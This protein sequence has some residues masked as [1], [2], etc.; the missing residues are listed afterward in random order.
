MKKYSPFIWMI[1]FAS[2]LSFAQD[3]HQYCR[4]MEHLHQ[5]EAQAHQHLLYTQANALTSDYD[6]KYHRLAWTIDPAKRFVAG[7]ITSY[8][9]P[10]V[11][12][13]TTIHFDFSDSLSVKEA[14][15]NGLPLNTQ[16]ANNLL[17]IELPYSLNTGQLDSVTIAYEGVPSSTGFGAFEQNQHNGQP[18]IWTLSEPYGAREWWP[19]KQNLNDKIDSIDIFVTTPLGNRVA[20]N[21]LLISTTEVDDQATF[22]WKHRYPIPA[23]LIAIAVT[24]Y[25]AY[26]D[27]VPVENGEDIEVLN[28]VYPENL[29]A[30][31]ERTKDII[32]VM[33]LFNNLFGLYPFADEKYGH[34][35]F[36][37]GGGM[38]HQTMSF[39]GTFSYALQAHELA[40]QWFGNKVTCGSWEDIW[41]NEGFATYLTGIS[42]ENLGS[43]NLWNAWKTITTDKVTQEPDGSVWVSDTTSVSRIFNGRLSYDKGAMLLHMLRWEMGDQDFFQALNNY[44][45]DPEISFSYARTADLQRHLEMQS[46]RDFSEFFKDWFYGQGHPSYALNWSRTSD[47][48][49]IVIDQTTSHPSVDFFEMHLPVKVIGNGVDTL[50]RLAHDF[51]GQSYSIS[52]PFTPSWVFFDPD[53]WILSA[54]DN[55]TAL[56]EDYLAT[57]IKLS[58]NPSH[59]QVTID[60]DDAEALP[61][62]IQLMTMDGKVKQS[63]IPQDRLLRID[64][65]TL[66]AGQFLLRFEF[67]EG[68]AYRTLIKK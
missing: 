45:N 13:F 52:L 54:N 56:A 24:N 2:H 32:N 63:I 14:T 31:K 57:K 46:G 53:H 62:S 6:L 38:E 21:G 4:D 30:A 20:S 34:A 5:V 64:L 66:P 68:I 23:Y 33:D 15:A 44:L 27:F 17:T 29:E 16:H 47:G 26:S 42:Y 39:M 28:Y 67:L 12:D 10:K 11:D 61:I 41:L 36:G 7:E 55:T 22:H 8:F 37:W 9:L 65:T 43:E 51:S 58:P 49:D 19:C 59:D 48:L 35:Q 40:H 18:I 60:F 3:I 50:L 1:C 25:A